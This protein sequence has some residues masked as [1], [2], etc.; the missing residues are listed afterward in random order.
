MF[1]SFKKDKE[2]K[3]LTNTFSFPDHS[4]SHLLLSPVFFL[5]PHSVTSA[6]SM[7]DIRTDAD[8]I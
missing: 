1:L 8:H 2:T 5:P 4:A 3:H 6:Q 7:S